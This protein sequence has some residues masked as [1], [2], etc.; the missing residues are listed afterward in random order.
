MSTRKIIDTPWNTISIIPCLVNKGVTTVIRYYGM[1]SHVHPEKV[2]KFD[3]AKA[4]S[5]AGL[6]IAV[7][8]EMIN[9]APEYFS[10]DLGLKHA[11][12]AFKLAKAINQPINSAIYFAVDFDAND[13]EINKSIIPHFNGIKDGLNEASNGQSSYKIG[14]Y[15]SGK[16]I[17]TIKTD[18]RWLSES[19]GWSQS[20]KALSDGDYELCQYPGSSDFC[21][22]D[23]NKFDFNSKKTETT[24][25]G[26]F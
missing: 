4:L 8:F 2:L 25:I 14:I 19:M 17:N 20:R 5:N 1:D 9:N 11:H 16:V 26:A 10:Y 15:G 23:A 7:V 21:W 6:K 12:I 18:Y 13:D 22:N 3:E 24:D